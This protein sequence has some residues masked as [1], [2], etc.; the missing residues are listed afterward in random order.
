M[1]LTALHCHHLCRGRGKPDQEF[2]I[3]WRSLFWRCA[4]SRN[5]RRAA[6]AAREEKPTKAAPMW[7]VDAAAFPVGDESAISAIVAAALACY[8]SV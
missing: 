6:M 7:S 8:L 5:Q 1:E 2:R 4:P 3:R